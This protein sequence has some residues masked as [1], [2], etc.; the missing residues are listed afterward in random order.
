MSCI[1]NALLIWFFPRFPASEQ[2][3]KSFIALFKSG[4]LTSLQAQDTSSTS[5]TKLFA[6]K[7]KNFTPPIDEKHLLQFPSKVRQLNS[8]EE[9]VMLS[10]LFSDDDIRMAI[11]FGFTI[12]IG[13]YPTAIA[14]RTQYKVEHL[15]KLN[16]LIS[17]NVLHITQ[18]SKK[19]LPA[20]LEPL[21]SLN[22]ISAIRKETP[23]IYSALSPTFGCEQT[24]GF[25]P[26]H[27]VIPMENARSF[28]FKHS[29][30][31]TD[32]TDDQFRKVQYHFNLEHSYH[33]L[34]ALSQAL[35][36][37]YLNSPNRRK[38][39][40]AP[41]SDITLHFSSTKHSTSTITLPKKPKQDT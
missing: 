10:S 18:S 17:Y 30:Q 15:T 24:H 23:S 4:R 13:E 22:I 33:P 5:A 8:K 12:E 25:S 21:S 29:D 16:E 41:A 27:Y 19:D 40:A 31:S 11:E 9:K 3:Y 39:P 26:A 37:E 32:P 6:E 38:R 35:L 7:L 36:N 34:I 1:T 2:G 14:K 28:V 20:I